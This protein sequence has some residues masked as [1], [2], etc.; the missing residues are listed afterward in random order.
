[1][2][3]TGERTLRYSFPAKIDS[4]THQ[5]VMRLRTLALT[6]PN[7]LEA[8]PGYHTV[9]IYVNHDR[10]MTPVHTEILQAWPSSNH[11]SVYGKLHKIPVCYNGEDLEQLAH[12]KNLTTQQVIDIHASVEYTIYMIG[13]LPG[14]PYLGGLDER[15]H[16]PRRET[17]RKSVPKGSIGIGGS[18]TGIYPIE[19]PGGWHLIGQTPLDI[20]SAT[21]LERPF[22]FQAGDRI[23]FTEITEDDYQNYSGGGV[24]DQAY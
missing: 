20:F 10:N 7:V 4:N 8:V 3:Q 11:Q 15:L 12:S 14:F 22:L 18:Q 23:Q 13:F 24:I 17:P 21:S 6:L 16:T 1:M 19:S 2:H 9:T 5:H